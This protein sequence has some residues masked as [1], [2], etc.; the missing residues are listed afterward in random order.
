MRKSF[1]SASLAFLFAGVS[2]QSQATNL[3]DA[4]KD[5][6][7][8]D[9]QILQAKARYDLARE[10]ESIAFS[11]LL[12]KINLTAGYSIT[13]SESWSI[14]NNRAENFESDKLSYGV[15]LSQTLFNMGTWYS[16]DSAEKKAL[17]AQT[18]YDLAQQALISRVT[19]AY[20]GV[21]KAKDNLE[22]VIAEKKAIERQLEQTK[23]KF[24]VGLEAI[25]DVH[26]AQ[27]N[28][29]N[30]VAQEIRAKN[31]IE[32]A[33]EALR[34][35]T[36]KYY[37]DYDGINTDRFEAALP[38]PLKI[39]SWVTKSENHN[40]ELKGKELAVEA[41]KYDIKQA[42]SGHYPTLN[43]TAGLSVDD[44]T[45]T[46]GSL[47][48]DQDALNTTQIGLNLTVPLYSGGAT[49]ASVRQAQA[50][51]VIASEDMELTHRSVVRQVRSSF[52]D[53]VALV[54][55]IKALQQSVVS[56]ESALKA[57]QAGFDVGTRTIVDVLNS[58]RNLYNAKRNLSN[59]RYDYI[60]AT[61]SLKQASGSLSASDVEGVNRGLN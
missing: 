45:R 19:N 58:T 2:F 52:A 21:L 33:K 12:P 15:N 22:F 26:E 28:F 18:G 7:Q 39:Q 6:V 42:N 49:S 25:T 9:P 10:S 44:D 11:G 32:I 29:D 1:L 34:E 30:A 37:N 55:S 3:L 31:N 51:Y 54:S 38:S 24:N 35:I 23:Q 59:T 47:E 50:N 13:D 61:L 20:F 14:E 16:L 40:L 56:A 17:Q 57:T 36:G 27:A 43:L 4:Y 8:N 60:L 53:V 48:V 46:Y 5:A 41:A